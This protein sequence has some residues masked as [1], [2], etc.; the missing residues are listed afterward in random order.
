VAS[1]AAPA[2]AYHL[3]GHSGSALELGREL[4][5]ISSADHVLVQPRSVPPDAVF[6]LIDDNAARRDFGFNPRY[7]SLQDAAESL[8][9]PCK[10]G[11]MKETADDARE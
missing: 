8:V 2:S 10:R 11:D 3:V 7:A 9:T 1:L 5:D 6:P 4:L